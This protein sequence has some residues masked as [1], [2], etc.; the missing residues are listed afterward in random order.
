MDLRQ[1]NLQLVQEI[2]A[3]TKRGDTQM[4]LPVLSED[5]SSEIV[6][7]SQS[8]GRDK[9]IQAFQLSSDWFEIETF[10][11]QE[12]F[13]AGEKVV[14]LGTECSF[15]KTTRRWFEG[16]WVQIWTLHDGKVAHIRQFCDNA[17]LSAALHGD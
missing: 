16:D 3:A 7:I 2:Y 11:P 17:A 12:F 6:G 8:Q 4:I 15:I 5:V 1:Q 10:E 14:V 13:T 9:V